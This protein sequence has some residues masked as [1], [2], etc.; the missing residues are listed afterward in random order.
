MNHR[1]SQPIVLSVSCEKN[2]NVRNKESHVIVKIVL[3]LFKIQSV[4]SLLQ[5]SNVL[6]A[7]SAL[8]LYHQES[9]YTH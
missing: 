5:K 3:N 2:K 4:F 6:S 1:L 7:F 9:S 8:I